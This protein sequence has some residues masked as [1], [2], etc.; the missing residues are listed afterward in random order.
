MAQDYILFGPG[1]QPVLV[2]RQRK[3]ILCPTSFPA[4]PGLRSD[5][6]APRHVG[7]GQGAVEFPPSIFIRGRKLDRLAV[8]RHEAR[9]QS[10]GGKWWVER[11]HPMD[12]LTRVWV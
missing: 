7:A 4:A 11:R 6:T 1:E 9:R 5:G 3:L 12:F 8:R 10:D 2:R